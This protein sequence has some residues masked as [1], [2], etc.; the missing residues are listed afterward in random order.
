MGSLERYIEEMAVI[1]MLRRY[2][3]MKNHWKLETNQNIF[4]FDFFLFIYLDL[5]M[6][7]LTLM[8]TLEKRYW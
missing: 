7:P 3:L 5:L 8:L 2:L 1:L 4:Q 6:H